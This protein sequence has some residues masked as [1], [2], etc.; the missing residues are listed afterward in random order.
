MT[1]VD[2]QALPIEITYQLDSLVSIM[3]KSKEDVKKGDEDDEDLFYN[4]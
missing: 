4:T 2:D 3:K 1:I